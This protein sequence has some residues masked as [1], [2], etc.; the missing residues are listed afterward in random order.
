[1]L[2]DTRD[3]EVGSK[4]NIP[5]ETPDQHRWVIVRGN[6]PEGLYV[7]YFTPPPMMTGPHYA[8]LPH[9][10]TLAVHQYVDERAGTGQHYLDAHP[11]FTGRTG[12]I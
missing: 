7:M 1:M 5:G 9:S 8:V 11:D 2:I 4:L 6:H 10:R 3:I 12:E